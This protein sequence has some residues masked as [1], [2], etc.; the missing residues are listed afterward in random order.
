M[1]IDTISL[2]PK[3]ENEVTQEDNT[4][5][6]DY[7]DDS[8]NSIT[9]FLSKLRKLKSSQSKVRI[10]YFGDSFIEADYVT[11]EIR[12]RLQQR[13]G[14]N[15]V[16]FIPVQ[17]IVAGDYNSIHFSSG[18]SW[19]D[20]NFQNNPQKFNLGL[21]G[22]VFFSN[23][24]SS[25]EYSSLAQEDNFQTI[26][27]YT[28]RTTLND[29]PL[30]IYKDGRQ[31]T[32]VPNNNDDINETTL[33]ENIPINKFKLVCQD[34]NMPVYGISIEG[35]NGVYLDNYCFRGNTGLLSLQIREN[36]MQEFNKYFNYDLIIIH[37]GLNAI[38]HNQPNLF[39]FENGMNKLL[40]NIKAGFP[41]VPILLISTSDLGYRENGK[42]ITEPLV[43]TMVALQRKIAA[44]N[45]VAFWDLYTSMGGENTIVNWAEGDTVLAYRD[46]MHVNSKGGKKIGDIF[47]D[48]LLE[49]KRKPNLH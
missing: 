48:K 13:Y 4:L 47:I 7:S 30:E 34:K 28:G 19:V 38:E 32:I 23:G 18:T 8:S 29:G 1:P 2:N 14:G 45:K 20:Y 16:G 21:M 43:P 39:W 33:N 31:Q 24:N 5:I 44:Q 41:G 10:A 9:T 22:H 42:Y 11:D 35:N 40:Q 12:K 26:K 25:C 15:G 36:T 3:T 37:Y 6:A 17:S 46:Y 27:L 49:T